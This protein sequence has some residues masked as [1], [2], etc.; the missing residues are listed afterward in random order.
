MTEKRYVEKG[1]L[2]YTISEGA[3]REAKIAFELH[4]IDE[5]FSSQERNKNIDD[6]RKEFKNTADNSVQEAI[7]FVKNN[8]GITFSSSYW[9]RALTNADIIDNEEV[10][11]MS[12]INNTLNRLDKEGTIISIKEITSGP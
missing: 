11:S 6:F 10:N 8:L 5:D 12:L 3:S 2:I 4:L 7:D 1:G 9:D